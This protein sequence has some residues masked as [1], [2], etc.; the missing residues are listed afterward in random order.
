MHIPDQSTGYLPVCLGGLTDK[1]MLKRKRQREQGG[2]VSA[3]CFGGKFSVADLIV[4]RGR[5][6]R[7]E[8]D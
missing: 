5:I 7:T 8:Q 2:G 3:L 6:C 1:L 4:L